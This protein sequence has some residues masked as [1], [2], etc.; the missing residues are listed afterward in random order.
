M[1]EQ[2]KVEEKPVKKYRKVSKKKVCAFLRCWRKS[3]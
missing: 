2:V 1:S 3:D